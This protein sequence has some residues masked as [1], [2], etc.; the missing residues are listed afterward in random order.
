LTELSGSPVGEAFTSPVAV[1]VDPSGGYLYVANEGSSNI[2]GYSV[3]SDGGITLLAN[4]PFAGN[5]EPIFI[6]SDPAGKYL[7]VSNQ[8]TSP[9]LQTFSLDRSSGTLAAVATTGVGNT[10][11]GIALTQ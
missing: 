2:A 6:A 11:T 9:A 1:L 7:F 8:S 5:A 10:S 3:G 4:S